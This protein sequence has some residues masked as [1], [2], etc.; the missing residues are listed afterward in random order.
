M[1]GFGFMVCGF[2][3]RFGICV[4]GYRLGV[5]AFLKVGV[6]GIIVRD[7]VRVLGCGFETYGYG[8]R[9]CLWW[10]TGLSFEVYCWFL[11]VWSF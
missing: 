7:L 5:V 8:L 6:H 1:L 9:F 11:G 3:F 2:W 4:L 10:G